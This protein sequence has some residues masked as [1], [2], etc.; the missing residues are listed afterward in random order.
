[1]SV[2][3]DGKSI[4][5]LIKDKRV[6]LGVALGVLVLWNL[7][8]LFCDGTLGMVVN[9]VVLIVSSFVWGL[10]SLTKV[11]VV[12]LG[13]LLALINQYVH[14]VSLVIGLSFGLVV[15]KVFSKYLSTKKFESYLRYAVLSFLI[16]MLFLLPIRDVYLGFA[17]W[18]GVFGYV[19]VGVLALTL[20]V[21]AGIKEIKEEGNLL[22]VCLMVG[23][24]IFLFLMVVGLFSGSNVLVFGGG[25]MVCILFFTALEG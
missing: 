12:E 9:V 1:M 23:L 8:I 13:L 19:L 3:I 4:V 16:F 17:L 21:L 11:I 18:S 7:W 14:T 10:V 2:S 15:V 6:Q 25:I 24:A 20:L 22:F 5:S